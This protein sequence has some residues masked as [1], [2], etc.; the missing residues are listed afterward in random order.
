MAVNFGQKIA[1]T[2]EGLLAYITNELRN[3]AKNNDAAKVRIGA[4]GDH[5]G[6]LSFNK[7][8]IDP[9]T[10]TF[11]RETELGL[12]QIKQDERTRNDVNGSRGELTIH[13][14]DGDESKPED[15][16]Q[17]PVLLVRTDGYTWLVPN[18]SNPE[19]PPDNGHLDPPSTGSYDGAQFM[20]SEG[21]FL[22]ARQTDGHDVLYR[23][24]E[25][26]A[27]THAI[28]TSDGGPNGTWIGG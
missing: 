11:T 7:I 26:G 22:Y 18:V 5:G 19:H 6:C 3:Y 28:W 4:P 24:D 9:N 23:I 1:E 12:F 8:W 2:A 16:R 17:R 14:S 27:P 10:G 15:Q 25:H 20:G 13:L 21:K